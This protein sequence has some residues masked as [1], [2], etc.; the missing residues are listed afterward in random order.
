MSRIIIGCDPGVAGA[1]V[2]LSEKGEL[3][4]AH[5]MPTYEIIKPKAKKKPKADAPPKKKPKKESDV[6]ISLQ[7]DFRALFDLIGP[8]FTDGPLRDEHPEVYIEEITHLFGLPSQTNFKLG[9]AVGVLTAAVQVYA[10]EFFIVQPKKWQQ[11]VWIEADMVYKPNKR[12]NTGETS[13][14]AFNRIF[15]NWDGLNTDGVRDAALIAYY[16]L[17]GGL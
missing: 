12:V 4:H 14:N 11:G 5:R 6:K 15:P 2:A 17:K 13:R 3:L 10:E 16:A 8:Y 9:H 7:V 1:I